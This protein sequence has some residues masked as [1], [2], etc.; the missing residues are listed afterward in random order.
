MDTT[1]DTFK[2]II[3][4]AFFYREKREQTEI[5]WTMQDGR[6]FSLQVEPKSTP[7]EIVE[8]IK[9]RMEQDGCSA[10][11]QESRCP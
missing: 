5:T 3:E 10:E 7:T 1:P 4:L 9:R 11:G 8:A 2:Q 6:I